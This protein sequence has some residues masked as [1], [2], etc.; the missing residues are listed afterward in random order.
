MYCHLQRGF[1]RTQH[2]VFL[3]PFTYASSWSLSMKPARAASSRPDSQ[4]AVVW[5]GL[6]IV[7]AFSNNFI[8]CC[9]AYDG[10]MFVA[11]NHSESIHFHL[12]V[13]RWVAVVACCAIF[14][15]PLP[16][17]S[18]QRLRSHQRGVTQP[19]IHLFE[20]SFI[21][22]GL[23]DFHYCPCRQAWFGNTFIPVTTVAAT[24]WGLGCKPINSR[25]VASHPGRTA[26]SAWIW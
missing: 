11:T 24:F 6:I 16:L 21:A 2:P 18:L 13:C 26:S 17:L 25:H 1:E 8:Q 12:Q 7:V 15:T 19:L 5:A 3:L 20:P 9:L 10:F 23:V 14:S 4:D 22:G